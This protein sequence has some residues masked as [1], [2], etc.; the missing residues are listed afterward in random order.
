LS[1]LFDNRKTAFLI[2]LFVSLIV[3]IFQNDKFGF[4]KGH[5]G[6]LSSHGASIARNLS[7]DNHFLMFTSRW[8]DSNDNIQFRAY[9][10]FPITSFLLLKVAMSIA[11]PD[12]SMQISIA[13]Q[14]MNLFFLGALIFSFLSFY[15]LSKNYLV[16]L[17]VT[18]LSF[19]SVYLNYYNDMIFNDIPTLFGVIMIGHGLILYE[20]YGKKLQMFVKALIGISLGWQAFGILLAYILASATRD[21]L[22]NKSISSVLKGDT[23]R[24]G[25]ISFIFGVSILFYNLAVESYITNKSFGK[26]NTLT[27]ARERLGST[28]GFNKKY[29]EYL[30][31]DEFTKDQMRRVGAMTIPYFFKQGGNF[32]LYGLTAFLFVVLSL[33]FSEKPVLIFSFLFSGVLWAFPMK[34]FT[35]SHDFQSIFYIGIPLLFYYIIINLIKKRTDFLLLAIVIFSTFIFIHTN[36]TLNKS[37]ASISGPLNTVIMDITGKDNTFYIDGDRQSIAGGYYTVDFCLAGNYFS[38]RNNAEYLVSRNRSFS[39]PLL[40]PGNSAFFLFSG[41]PRFARA[42]NR[43]GLDYLKNEKYNLAINDFEKAVENNPGFVE[44]YINLGTAEK[45]RNHYDSVIENFSK[46]LDLDP[47]SVKALNS[48]AWFLATCKS[49]KFRDGERAIILSKKAIKMDHNP[50]YLDT[51][52]AAYAEQGK[53]DMAVMTQKEVIRFLRGKLDTAVIDAFKKRLANYR[54]NQ[55]WRE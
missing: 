51:L 31:W 27:S 18:F 6:F 25:L 3:L 30:A 39:S 44:A 4:E 52:A 14:V 17:S 38:E 36:I 37:K 5:H 7:S 50:L 49:A 9:S 21:I 11:G 47:K 54:A 22:K 40:T 15:E 35:F 12:L 48:S 29:S 28:E 45:K 46:A 2:I 43:R 16:A 19:S 23:L 8:M 41:K 20:L 24:L 33:F 26:L 32:Y 55:P 13:R 10:R 42:F 53:F 1:N 34:N